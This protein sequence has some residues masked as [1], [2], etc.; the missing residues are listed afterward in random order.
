MIAAIAVAALAVAAP[1]LGDDVLYSKR[2]AKRFIDD[3]GNF[4]MCK[5]RMA[6]TSIGGV[7]S[8]PS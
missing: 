6:G 3:E 7:G 8:H 2:M 1:V 5:C 4:N